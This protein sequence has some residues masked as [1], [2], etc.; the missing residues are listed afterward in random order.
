MTRAARRRFTRLALGLPLLGLLTPP[1]TAQPADTQRRSVRDAMDREQSIPL[2]PQRVLALSERDLDCLLA[3]ELVPVAASQGRAQQGFPPYLAARAAGVASLGQ[4]A[5]PS[6]D[7]VIAARPDL[8]LAGGLADAKLLAQ[9]SRIAPTLVSHSGAEPWPRTLQRIA[10]WT[11]RAERVAP[12]MQRHEQ[13]VAELRR[14][15]ARQSGRSVSLVR[16]T[17]QGPVYMKGEAF[18]GLLLGELGFTRPPRQQEAGA[19]HS[20]PLSREALDQIDADWLLIG[21]FASGPAHDPQALAGLMARPE[22]RELRATRGGRVRE[23]DAA[24]WTV[25]GGPLAALAVLDDVQRL[26]LP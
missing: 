25:T 13:R 7:R 14:P 4:F 5:Q 21:M 26:M 11:G 12:L 22:F 2:R 9:L 6:M 16:W 17:P 15:L 20:A 1:A 18:A 8:I 3:L 10:D 19:G 23:V 24:L